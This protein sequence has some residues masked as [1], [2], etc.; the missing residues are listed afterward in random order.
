MHLN[1]YAPA[2][3][4]PSRAL[5]CVAALPKSQMPIRQVFRFVPM[6][7]IGALVQDC[8]RAGMK[9]VTVVPNPSG[10]S[11]TLTIES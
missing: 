6:D 2:V 10:S 1:T 8:L 5:P 9:K 11:C 3:S 7:G 4:P